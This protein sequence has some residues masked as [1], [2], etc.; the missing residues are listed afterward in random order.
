GGVV[1]CGSAL[2]KQWEVSEGLYFLVSGRLRAVADGEQGKERMGAEIAPGESV[3]EMGFLTDE[4]RSRSVYA[5]R[6]STLAKFS[7]ESFN[8]LLEQY[9]QALRHIS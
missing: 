2:L 8:R 3:G 9:P 7:R 6:D 4:P 1:H 5:I